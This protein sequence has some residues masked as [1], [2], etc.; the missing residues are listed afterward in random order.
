MFVFNRLDNMRRTMEALLANTQARDTKL[1][2]FSDG[3]RDDKTRR[4]VRAVRDYLNETKER[5]ERRGLMAGVTIV[6]RGQNLYVERN[7]TEGIKQVLAEEDRIIVLEDDIVTSPYFLEYMNEALNLYSDVTRVMHV[8]GF[9]NLSLTNVDGGRQFYFTPHTSGWGWATWRDRWQTHFRPYTSKE[10]AL[11]GMTPDNMDKMQYGGAF[12]CL[13]SLEKDPIPWD[14][15]WEIAIY[16]AR[17]LC[18]TP[19]RTMVRNIGLS[20]GTHFRSSGLLQRYEYDREPSP[21]PIQL[22]KEKNPAANPQT[23]ALFAEAITDWGIR[24]TAL[25]KAVRWIYKKVKR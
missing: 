18:L 7:I 6:E 10:E 4:Q 2:V 13:K 1:Y 9:T 24:Y 17:G 14:I 8:S 15:C 23:E 11:A 20:H 21:H 16:K 5:I 22:E 25:G 12:P 19:A 3:G